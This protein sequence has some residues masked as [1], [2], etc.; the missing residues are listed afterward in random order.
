VHVS[1]PVEDNRVSCPGT[2]STRGFSEGGPGN[3]RS[4]TRAGVAVHSQEHQTGGPEEAVLSSFS[5][6]WYLSGYLC[7]CSPPPPRAAG[8][9]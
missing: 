7:P 4:K 3:I 9:A 5:A 8:A 6:A 1:S 2:T